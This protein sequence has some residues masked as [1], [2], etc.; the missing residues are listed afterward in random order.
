MIKIRNISLIIMF[1]SLNVWEIIQGCKPST[2][3]EENIDTVAVDTMSTAIFEVGDA[4]FC[5]PSPFQAA[6]LIKETGMNYDK[7]MTNNPKKVATYTTNFQK[8]LNLGSYGADLGY[9]TIYEQPQDAILFFQS[10]EELAGELGLTSAFNQ[11]TIE[12]IRD[13]I[14]NRDSLLLLVSETYRASD[15]YLKNNARTDISALILAGGWVES[16]NF[17]V[18]IAQRN[19]KN[20]EVINR[21]GEQKNPLENLIKILTPYYDQPEYTELIDKLIE[22]AYE[23]DGVDIKYTFVKP[24]VDVQNKVTYINNTSEVIISEYQLKT[25]SERILA[26]RNY[27]IGTKASG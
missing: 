7:E 15:E 13:N 17:L 20:Q 6:I 1:F 10:V 23:F 2:E 22:L 14:G 11:K 5:I 27:I 26:I 25:I 8:A 21:I 24:T 12:R 9:S 18:N 16:V 19:P 4:L 3:K